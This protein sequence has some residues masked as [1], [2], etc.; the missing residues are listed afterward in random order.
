MT[1]APVRF[2]RVGLYYQT[3]DGQETGRWNAA[4]ERWEKLAGDYRK[5]VRDGLRIA[6]K[7]APPALLSLPFNAPEAAQ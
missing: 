7:Q 3:L 1:G 5:S 6:R 2:G 4:G